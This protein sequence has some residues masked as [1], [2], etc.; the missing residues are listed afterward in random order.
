MT[1][2]QHRNR[3]R[4]YTGN[5]VDDARIGE[6]L[7]AVLASLW[8]Y[9]WS[10]RKQTA[11]LVTT[12]AYSTGTVALN[13]DPTKVDGTG[14]AWTSA[15]VGRFLRVANAVSF[16]RITAV[17][18]QQLTLEAAYPTPFDAG[19]SYTI[20]QLFYPLAADVDVLQ[21][22]AYW[23][24]LVETTVEGMDRVDAQRST[25]GQEP[26]AFLYQGMDSAGRVQIELRPVPSTAV[27]LRYSYLS[28]APVLVPGTDDAVEIPL[29]ADLLDYLATAEALYV[30]CAE[31]ADSP[32]A[33]RLLNLA[34]RH[35]QRGQ[36]ALPE[37]LFQDAKRAGVA[38]AGR[39][40]MFGGSPG[41]FYAY[42][43]DTGFA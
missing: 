2:R 16:Y 40:E 19:S 13:G 5:R 20:F 30:W 21:S 32:A 12:P 11:L 4:M 37:A 41:D 35:E 6:V 27:A 7:N 24:R 43:H 34:T 18:G 26:Y 14:T 28:T 31:H 15:L 3:V 38:Q 1:Y 9:S 17:S 39:D 25:T 8:S 36:A 33:D 23:H 22:Q 29:D 10:F 42:E